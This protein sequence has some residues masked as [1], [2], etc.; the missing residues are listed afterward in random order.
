MSIRFFFAILSLSDSFT[1][2]LERWR[3]DIGLC[4]FALFTLVA[5]KKKREWT[6][7]CQYVEFYH[8]T[9][10]RHT[11]DIKIQLVFN[12]M[13]YFISSVKPFKSVALKFETTCGVPN[14]Y[15]Y[16]CSEFK[17]I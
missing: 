2:S 13:I 14:Y 6:L 3:I 10:F 7:E 4:K 12:N 5:R 1:S 9:F 16:L 17:N 11:H 15:Y 8:S